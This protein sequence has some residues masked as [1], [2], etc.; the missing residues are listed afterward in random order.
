MS[1]KD[2]DNYKNIL[3]NKKAVFNYEI[4]DKY[5]CGIT[6]TG[7]EVKSIREGRASFGDS[8]VYIQNKRVILKGFTIQSYTHASEFFNHKPL[9]EHYLLLHKDEIKKLRRKVEEKGFTLVP[10]R[11]YLK[12]NLIK[13]EI[14]LCKGRD[15][16]SKKQ[17]IK[18][19]DIDRAASREIKELNKY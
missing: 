1:K 15:L 2:E 6:L 3:I 10:Y 9:T 4:I 16:V 7:T 12:K 17:R 5:E 18:E 8:Y 14:V 11:V 19:R 13:M